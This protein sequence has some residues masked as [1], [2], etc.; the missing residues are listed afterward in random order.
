MK[1]GKRESAL[2][3][4]ELEEEFKKFPMR[5]D[6]IRGATDE[7]AFDQKMLAFYRARVAAGSPDPVGD[8]EKQ[9]GEKADWCVK[10][11][12]F[13]YSDGVTE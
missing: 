9:F 11:V 4:L 3:D 7:R 10:P 8:T 13:T 5:T 2:D 1:T 6:H 12:P